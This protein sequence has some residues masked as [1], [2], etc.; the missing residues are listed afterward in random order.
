MSAR[1]AIAAA[2]STVDGITV[3]PYFNQDMTVGNGRVRWDRT[4][5]PNKFGGT[6]T[7]QV[8]MNLPADLASAEKWMERTL[9]AIR[10][11][12]ATEMNVTGARYEQIQLSTG[13]THVF[14][15][16]EGTREEE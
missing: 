5:H 10:D 3:T 13:G 12:V 8:V 1:E 11:A 2:A 7:W 4:E 9:P 16:I 15:L 6:A 14:A